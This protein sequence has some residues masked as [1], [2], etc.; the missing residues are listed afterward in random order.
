MK[1]KKSTWNAFARRS[2]SLFLVI[3]MLITSV[4]LPEIDWQ[5]GEATTVHGEI[6]TSTPKFVWS[7]DKAQSI[8]KSKN[9]TTSFGYNEEETLNYLKVT[10]TTGTGVNMN[11]AYGDETSWVA[12]SGG[13]FVNPDNTTITKTVVAGQT[14]FSYADSNAL[15]NAS[16]QYM[17]CFGNAWFNTIPK[18]I[19]GLR[20]GVDTIDFSGISNY[21][22]GLIHFADSNTNGLDWTPSPWSP[23]LGDGTRYAYFLVKYKA[24]GYVPR[25]RVWGFGQQYGHFVENNQYVREV[26]QNNRTSDEACAAWNNY[27]YKKTKDYDQSIVYAERDF[28]MGDNNIQYQLIWTEVIH[29]EYGNGME[30]DSFALE[31]NGADVNDFGWDNAQENADEE[32]VKA[33]AAA[34]ANEL[35]GKDI[36]IYEV[37]GFD[38]ENDAIAYMYKDILDDNGQFTE[39]AYRTETLINAPQKVAIGDTVKAHTNNLIPG[40]VLNRGIYYGDR[41]DLDALPNVSY[42]SSIYKTDPVSANASYPVYDKDGNVTNTG[43]VSN[44]QPGHVTKGNQGYLET[45]SYKVNSF[46]KAEGTKYYYGVSLGDTSH[47]YAGTTRS[48]KVDITTPLDIVPYENDPSLSV[49][50]KYTYANP[51]GGHNY[52][53]YD[54]DF[55]YMDALYDAEGNILDTWS[56]ENFIYYLRAYNEDAAHL[57]ED[58][59][60]KIND[61]PGYFHTSTGSMT[62]DLGPAITDNYESVDFVY[63]NKTKSDKVTL[64]LYVTTYEDV[65][66]AIAGTAIGTNTY[67]KVITNQGRNKVTFNIPK[68]ETAEELGQT[69]CGRSTHVQNFAIRVE[70]GINDS[71]HTTTFDI[72]NIV[73]AERHTVEVA[74]KNE[75]DRNDHNAWDFNNKAI[76]VSHETVVTG[77]AACEAEAHNGTPGTIIY[78]TDSDGNLTNEKLVDNTNNIYYD[79]ANLACDEHCSFITYANGE[80]TVHAG[81]EKV[82]VYAVQQSDYNFAYNI[83]IGTVTGVA[84]TNTEAG[85]DNV[86]NATVG[87]INYG[88]SMFANTVINIKVIWQNYADNIQ[89]GM[90]TIDENGKVNPL[91]VWEQ[92]ETT[93]D[94]DIS[95]FAEFTTGEEIDNSETYGTNPPVISEVAYAKTAGKSS[96]YADGTVQVTLDPSQGG[97][98]TDIYMYYG[99]DSGTPLAN[100]MH[101][102]RQRVANNA[103]V[104][105]FNMVENTVIPAGAK[106]LVF[107][108]RAMNGATMI[109]KSARH[110]IKLKNAGCTSVKETLDTPVYTLNVVSDTHIGR[111]DKNG[112]KTTNERFQLMLRDVLKYEYY[113]K[114]TH[115]GIVIAGDITDNGSIDEYNTVLSLYNGEN[116]ENNLPKM[117]WAIGNHDWDETSNNATTLIDRF[118]TQANADDAVGKFANNGKPYYYAKVDPTTGN[119]GALYIYL[120]NEKATDGLNANISADQVEW[121]RDT[122]ATEHVDGMPIFVFCHQAIYNTV[123]GSLPGQ[124]WDGVG[125]EGRYDANEINLMMTLASYEEVIYF[126]GHSHW[127]LNSPGT[128]YKETDMM[129]DAFNT[130]SVGYLWQSYNDQYTDGGHYEDYESEGGSQGYYVE[131]YADGTILVRG[132]DFE[133]GKWLPSAQFIVENTAAKNPSYSYKD[134]GN[135]GFDPKGDST[136]SINKTTFGYGEKVI[137]SGTVFDKGFDQMYGIVDGSGNLVQSGYMLKGIENGDYNGKTDSKGN[138]GLYTLLFSAEV[139]DYGSFA[140][141][142]SYAPG[143]A[144]NHTGK[145]LLPPGTYYAVAFPAGAAYTNG[146]YDGKIEQGETWHWIPFTV[147]GTENRTVYDMDVTVSKD[148][149]SYGEAISIGY[150]NTFSRNFSGTNYDP[151]I[152]I[153]KADHTG[154]FDDDVIQW[155]Y[156][157]TNMVKTDYYNKVQEGVITFN[158]KAGGTGKNGDKVNDGGKYLD[159]GEYYAVVVL[160]NQQESPKVYFTVT[161]ESSSVGNYEVAIDK[162]TY[163]YGDN[164][165]VNYEAF[166]SLGTGTDISREQMYIGIW[167][168]SRDGSGTSTTGDNPKM[169][170][171]RPISHGVGSES[172]TVLND[173][174]LDGTFYVGLLYREHGEWATG[175]EELATFTVREMYPELTLD[176]TN[177]HKDET[178]G[179]ISFGDGEDIIVNYSGSKDTYRIAIT[180]ENGAILQIAK[181]LANGSIKFNDTGTSDWEYLGANLVHFR[182]LNYISLP[183]GKYR[184]VTLDGNEKEITDDEDVIWFSISQRALEI[185]FTEAGEDGNFTFNQR[186]SV[187]YTGSTKGFMVGLFKDGAVC[188]HP[189]NALQV[190][191]TTTEGT[192]VFNNYYTDE[193]DNNVHIFDEKAYNEVISIKEEYLFIGK[194]DYYIQ[195]FK[196]VNNTNA[197][198]VGN[199]LTVTISEGT[200]P[201]IAPEITEKQYTYVNNEYVGVKYSGAGWGYWLAVYNKA[202]AQ[203]TDADGNEYTKDTA[204][205]LQNKITEKYYIPLTNQDPFRAGSEYGND[206]IESKAIMRA[207]I[208]GDNQ[209]VEMNNALNFSGTLDTGT[210]VELPMLPRHWNGVEYLDPNLIVLGSQTETCYYTVIMFNEQND[211]VARFDITVTPPGQTSDDDVVI[212]PENPVVGYIGRWQSEAGV[213]VIDVETG[214]SDTNVIEYS[215]KKTF[216]AYPE[217]GYKFVGWYDLTPGGIV[218]SLISDKEELVYYNF[219]TNT[220][221]V[222]ALFKW[223]GTDESGKTLETE[224]FDVNFV[225]DAGLIMQSVPSVGGSAVDIQ[226]LIYTPP[227]KVGYTFDSWNIPS[228]ATRDVTVSYYDVD[229]LSEDAEDSKTVSATS[230]YY[231]VSGD[232]YAYDVVYKAKVDEYNSALDANGDV[233]EDP[234]AFVWEATTLINI[235]D[236]VKIYG[237]WVPASKQGSVSVAR[238]DYKLYYAD[239]TVEV[240][241]FEAKINVNAFVDTDELNGYTFIGW[242]DYSKPMKQ[243]YV[244]KELSANADLPAAE[245]EVDS[246]TPEGAQIK[247]YSNGT[248]KVN[249]NYYPIVCYNRYFSFRIG[250]NMNL[251]AVY[252]KGDY[253]IEANAKPSA[254][255]SHYAQYQDV[256]TASSTRV[257][258][259]VNA[260]VPLDNDLTGYELVEYGYL[261]FMAANTSIVPTTVF[262]N[263]NGDET[264]ANFLSLATVAGENSMFAKTVINQTNKAGQYYGYVSTTAAAGKTLYTRPYVIYKTAGTG[265]EDSNWTIAYGETLVLDLSSAEANDAFV[266][267][268]DRVE[269]FEETELTPGTCVNYN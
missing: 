199:K 11:S 229:P 141:R 143:H 5:K 174:D 67:T 147:T 24:D 38:S 145:S 251:Q 218:K 98:A 20:N 10:N 66:A 176:M 134:F 168:G 107:E 31:V 105:Q 108:A 8:I 169:W 81:K 151:W 149:Y 217:D 18:G 96:Y 135:D 14:K 111:A 267:A 260:I 95:T 212:D 132:R 177:A 142:Y 208:N 32:K 37:A 41:T 155:M 94:A 237:K 161:E 139:V 242:V 9:I 265:A 163:S 17:Y 211:E 19:T 233:T 58:D 269:I 235:T 154:T 100:Y 232:A 252:A 140:D 248:V 216:R 53:Q 162:E 74:F 49:L 113:N 26:Y 249:G 121:V 220:I 77:A 152:G 263:E 46:T 215:T 13:T 209:M 268:S 123:A 119:P 193:Y 87:H 207:W 122:L 36:L 130:G 4:T 110:M 266:G 124:G 65:D 86:I 62:Y 99:D 250:G 118:V 28:F 178:T 59:P 210:S 157:N 236:N 50:T 23:A 104:V 238:V 195:A 114:N 201:S 213:V 91:D 72:T 159:A 33:E 198:P 126:S 230:R 102:Q 71:V 125:T 97:I 137:V 15:G 206:E 223:V 29:D 112:D 257:R 203:Y 16:E 190:A 227:V 180:D 175:A 70:T 182:D 146:T 73:F 192:I 144:R 138:L 42:L 12:T 194:G 34:R 191:Y 83:D 120:G 79:I 204:G 185:K 247:I 225:N 254:T 85:K 136:F 39:K 188:D 27:K 196:F 84:G 261:N 264:V 109:S 22:Q 153:F 243:S 259:T 90:G 63:N 241:Y 3:A 1:M 231:V 93:V 2:A 150:G 184:I 205:A 25:M 52:Y 54:M 240:D 166:G 56:I 179:E 69:D 101:F 256:S 234:A 170:Y 246:T 115:H 219:Y 30:L 116:S 171:Y 131:V 89:A 45:L 262:Y 202:D 183:V 21:E 189:E 57:H 55:A 92:M 68:Y 133:D 64:T 148:T 88:F 181:T 128:Y 226:R 221:K 43:I 172:F 158:T 167:G 245:V 44:H 6:E 78:K 51:A 106:T 228:A 40:A 80:G 76:G 200:T 239:G 82:S 222:Y 255:I 244:L 103:T 165:T 127:D 48:G 258:T 253:D 117:F 164:I 173:M 75:K 35:K 160:K 197:V 214:D 187:D 156:A 224:I 47:L 61:M 7:A 186:I 129:S 60:T